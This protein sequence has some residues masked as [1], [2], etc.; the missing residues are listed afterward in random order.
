M[1]QFGVAETAYA[2]KS[3][4]SVGINSLSVTNSDITFGKLLN[5][6]KFVSLSVNQRF[7]H[8]SHKIM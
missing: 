3:D 5:T 7:L 2:L 8:L 6:F 4:G 1:R